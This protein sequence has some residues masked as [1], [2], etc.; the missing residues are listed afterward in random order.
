LLLNSF[1]HQFLEKSLRRSQ[2]SENFDFEEEVI[3]AGSGSRIRPSAA[4][5]I[6]LL[7][8]PSGGPFQRIKEEQR[9]AVALS[10]GH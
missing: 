9:E 2:I 1:H 3:D 4:G 7:G 10:R 5:P 6:L 8:Q